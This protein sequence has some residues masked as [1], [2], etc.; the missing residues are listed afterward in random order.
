[1]NRAARFLTGERVYLRPINAE[2]AEWY[3]HQLFGSETRRLTGTQK[4]YTKEQIERYV[5]K[6]AD[7][8]S[9]VLLL[10]A[11]NENDETIGDIAI[12]D[13]DPM[14]RN[15][16]IRI[17]VSEEH[18]QGKG[19]GREA[20]RLMLEYGF[21]ILNLHRIELEVYSYNNRA[22]HMYEGLGFTKEGVRREA[23]Y[24]NHEYHDIITMSLLEKE[25]R[26]KFP[27]E[28]QKRSN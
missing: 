25:Y 18:R 15:A 26:Q 8:A 19:Y 7:D 24:Y 17:A 22:L 11:L 14:N 27:S 28:G 23:L 20:L 16:N 3:Y 10:I 13:I 12:Q 6:K 5:L 2:D 1:M 9:A 21:G 4:I